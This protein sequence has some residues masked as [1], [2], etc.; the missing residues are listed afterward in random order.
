M[1]LFNRINKSTSQRFVHRMTYGRT[2]FCEIAH[3]NTK[4]IKSKFPCNSCAS[5]SAI[6]LVLHL[7]TQPK[8]L[9]FF[10]LNCLNWSCGRS[11]EFQKS[12]YAYQCGCYNLWKSMWYA[13][14]AV[15][16]IV[17]DSYS[18]W[19]LFGVGVGIS[20]ST[21]KVCLLI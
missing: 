4:C 5:Q 11:T 20:A 16:D 17:G 3:T 7:H 18:Y 10:A 14:V 2:S 9:S 12:V 8:Y 21:A 15:V 6:N 13:P 19:V 1:C